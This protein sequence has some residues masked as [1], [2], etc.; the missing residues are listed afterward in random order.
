M[1]T[2][3]T[4]HNHRHLA[5]L[6]YTSTTRLLPVVDYQRHHHV[7]QAGFLAGVA[8]RIASRLLLGTGRLFLFPEAEV[9]LEHLTFFRK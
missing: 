4:R 2:R 9:P 7:R 1:L 6:G 3:L 8:G 5:T